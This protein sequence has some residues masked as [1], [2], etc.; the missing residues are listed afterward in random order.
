MLLQAET[1]KKKQAAK[2]EISKYDIDL[3]ILAPGEVKTLTVCSSSLTRSK[4][5]FMT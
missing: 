5:M 3:G 4:A 2:E 1:N